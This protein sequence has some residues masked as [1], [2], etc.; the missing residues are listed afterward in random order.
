M[1]DVCMCPH[2]PM[3]PCRLRQCSCLCRAEASRAPLSCPVL[4][5]RSL[6]TSELPHAQVHVHALAASMSVKA[7]PLNF[8]CGSRATTSGDGGRRVA[9]LGRSDEDGAAHQLRHTPYTFGSPPLPLRA[10]CPC[11]TRAT[12]RAPSLQPASLTRSVFSLAGPLSQATDEAARGDGG[13]Q[14]GNSASACSSQGSHRSEVAGSPGSLPGGT[15]PV[16]RE[17]PC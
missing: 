2:A 5:S 13:S 14:G 6:C 15:P 7:A 9:R 16:R 12:A 8:P 1:D 4:R 3:R 17:H 11:K 10:R